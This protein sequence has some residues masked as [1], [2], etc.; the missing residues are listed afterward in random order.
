MRLSFWFWK[1]GKYPFDLY[2]N[3][4]LFLLVIKGQWWHHLQVIL[5]YQTGKKSNLDHVRLESIYIFL[6]ETDP[7]KYSEKTDTIL[8]CWWSQNTNLGFNWSAINSVKKSIYFLY[9]IFFTVLQMSYSN[10]NITQYKYDSHKYTSYEFCTQFIYSQL[11][12]S[13]LPSDCYMISC[14]NSGYFVH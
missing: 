9:T 2:T 7:H 10:T 5:S 3:Y 12:Y 6:E 8:H 11:F 4:W 14:L 13:V 1:F